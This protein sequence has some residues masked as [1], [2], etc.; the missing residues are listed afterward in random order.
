MRLF[1]N[2]LTLAAWVVYPKLRLPRPK[3]DGIKILVIDKVSYLRVDGV[4]PSKQLWAHFN[5]RFTSPLQAIAGIITA[6]FKVVRYLE[7]QAYKDA[8]LESATEC[9]AIVHRKEL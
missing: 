8:V 1:T 2:A 7:R 6:C 4:E 3:L 5:R 9:L